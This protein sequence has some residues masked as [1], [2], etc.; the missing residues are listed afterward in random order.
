MSR[1]TAFRRM[2]LLAILALGLPAAGRCDP[3]PP[4]RIGASLSGSGKYSEP[5]AMIRDGYRLWEQQVNQRGGLLGRPVELII[6]AD[7]SHPET[8]QD[9]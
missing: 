8:A 4:V 5:S 7:R 9:L 3:L 6:Y 1:R 2:C